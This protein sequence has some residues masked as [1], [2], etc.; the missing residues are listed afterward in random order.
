MPTSVVNGTMTTAKA[1]TQRIVFLDW[2]RIIAFLGVLAG[3][4]YAP[5]YITAMQAETTP[6]SLR[7]VMQVFFPLIQNG[8]AGVVLFFLVSGYI[9]THVLMREGH[10]MFL[11]RRFFRIYPLYVLAV[12]AELLCGQ[13]FPG[14]PVLLAQLSLFGDAF[15]ARH[16]LGGVEWTLRVEVLFYLFMAVL[17]AA[18]IV[19]GR[20]CRVMP[21]VLVTTMAVLFIVAPMPGRWAWCYGYLNLYGPFLLLG[22]CFYLLEH[23]RLGVWACAG[24][25]AFALLGYWILLSSWQ[26]AFRETHFTG[27]AFVVFV[28]FWRLRG[29]LSIGAF[30]LAVSELTYAVYLFHDWLYQ[31]LF[32]LLGSS[33]ASSLLGHALTFM[34]LMAVCWLAT[35]CVE[36]PMIRAGQRLSNR[37]RS[38][39]AASA[40]TP[41]SAT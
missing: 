2:L 26:P 33:I 16:T 28:L 24:I 35:R 38:S 20:W 14:W 41:I 15:H 1:P 10:G 11:V 34:A 7:W 39:A 17:K 30:G 27:Y 4:E 13:P 40:A 12:L 19:D 25:S 22:A 36:Q 29:S 31:R 18:G 23:G 21:L 8:G 6:A 9:I 32:G 37:W 3:H 5:A